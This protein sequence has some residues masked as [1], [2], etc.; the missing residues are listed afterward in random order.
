MRIE[1]RILGPLEVRRDDRPVPSAGAK[2]R[3]PLAIL[4]LRANEPVTVDR[5]VDDLWGRLPRRRR[6]SRFRSA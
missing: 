6:E 2:E 1:F 3:A 5:L 4:L